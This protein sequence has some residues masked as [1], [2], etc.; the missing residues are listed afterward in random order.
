MI[1]EHML[2]REDLF[3]VEETLN[4]AALRFDGHAYMARDAE[5]RTP[6]FFQHLWQRLRGDP[7]LRTSN[8]DL[9]ASLFHYQRGGPRNMGW[10]AFRDDE[11]LTGLRLWLRLYD[12]PTPAPWR[13]EPYARQWDCRTAGEKAH[14]ASVVRQWLVNGEGTWQP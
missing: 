6:E 14:A 3:E 7:N 5:A 1:P 2:T 4:E 12:S 11:H 8:E 9:M 13:L 10:F